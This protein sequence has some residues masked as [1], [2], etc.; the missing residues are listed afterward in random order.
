MTSSSTRIS[1]ESGRVA[2][3]AA[4][5]RWLQEYGPPLLLYARQ[6]TS[7]LV[8]A[9]EAVQDGFVRFWKAGL[10]SRPDPK[11]ALY[12]CV[13]SAALDQLRSRQRRQAREQ[14]A[15]ELMEA[16]KPA[17][18]FN[19]SLEQGEWREEVERAMATL[20]EEQRQVLVLKIWGDLTF[21]QIADIQELP[22]N[23]VASRYRYAFGSL[24]KQLGVKRS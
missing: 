12:T 7:S 2:E 23:T 1:R 8:E 3:D 21:R 22:L 9:E 10:Q 16:E 18:L 11:P 4:W 20:P 14:R 15:A 24:R 6:W 13:R 17:P 19:D 5:Q